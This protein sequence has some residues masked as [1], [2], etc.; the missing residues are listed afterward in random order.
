MLHLNR[1]N[2]EE[3][4]QIRFYQ[5]QNGEIIGVK[6]PKIIEKLPNKFS[7][8]IT[9]TKDIFAATKSFNQEFP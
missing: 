2:I 1:F 5:K 3:I 9:S 6:I 4:V 8:K 7:A